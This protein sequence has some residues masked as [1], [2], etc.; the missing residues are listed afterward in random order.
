M[1]CGCVLYSRQKGKELMGPV[2]DIRRLRLYWL[3]ASSDAKICIF[4]R[5]GGFSDLQAKVNCLLGFSL[6]SVMMMDDTRAYISIYCLCKHT[7]LCFF[8]P[9]KCMLAYNNDNNVIYNLK[10]LEI[11]IMH[12]TIPPNLTTCFIK[13][14]F[15]D[16]QLKKS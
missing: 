7:I 14:F 8:K 13:A 3:M 5:K 2:K 1:C 6:K 16:C 4:G 9:T 15:L 11:Y 10:G 12:K